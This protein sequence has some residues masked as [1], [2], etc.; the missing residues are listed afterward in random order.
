MKKPNPKKDK[1]AR[2][3]RAGMVYANGKHSFISRLG[4]LI[5]WRQGTD[6]KHRPKSKYSPKKCEGT[7]A[8]ERR[9][10]RGW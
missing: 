1:A 5:E 2:R 4:E 6:W 3:Q 9:A 8:A 10:K 7:K